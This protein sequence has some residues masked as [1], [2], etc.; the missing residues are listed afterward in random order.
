MKKLRSIGIGALI[1]ASV[2]PVQA[3]A[4]PASPDLVRARTLVFGLDNVDQRTG[5]VDPRK[6]V[7]SWITN[8]SYAASVKGRIVLLDSYVDRAETVPGRTP[9]VVEDLLSLRP[10][11]IF[12]GHGHTDHANNAAWLAGNIGIPIYASAETCAAMQVDAQQLF[13][14][15][16]SP[17]SQV[18]CREVTS[19]GSTPGS[20]IV[21]I[22]QLQGVACITAFRHLHSTT[23]PADEDFPIIPVNNIPDPRDA[24]LYP[25]GTPHQFR[26]STGSGGPISILYQFVLKGDNH[27]SFVWNNTIGALKEG[28]GL[29]RCWG[30]AVGQQITSILESFSPTDVHIGSVASN[31]LGTNGTRDGILYMLALNPKVFYPAHLGF[32][33][34]GN[35]LQFKVP[36]LKQLDAMHVPA[37][38]RPEIRWVV[39]PNDYLRAE[40]FDPKD[41]RWKKPNSIK[42]NDSCK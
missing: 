39:D 16:N 34:P 38:A 21:K 12:L 27:F 24:T 3:Q 42:Y 30:P 5:E 8:A 1:L 37:D 36:F 7:V 41:D 14:A 9:F 29:D 22:K 35:S 11:A 15:G 19:T 6:V 23:V 18:D 40:V 10:E 32:Q 13:A 28:C 4:A 2:L 31:G 20:E 17:V 26:T 33:N 25:P